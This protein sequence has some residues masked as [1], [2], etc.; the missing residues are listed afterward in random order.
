MVP[1]RGRGWAGR[2][3]RAR[4]T[5]RCHPALSFNTMIVVMRCSQATEAALLRE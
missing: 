1:H 5:V 3:D 4:C 2:S